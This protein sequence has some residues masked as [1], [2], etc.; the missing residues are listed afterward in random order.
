MFLAKGVKLREMLPRKMLLFEKIIALL[1]LSMQ[2]FTIGS[3]NTQ[4]KKKLQSART[5][6]K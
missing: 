4:Q 2:S 1:R 3:T 6:S 5:S